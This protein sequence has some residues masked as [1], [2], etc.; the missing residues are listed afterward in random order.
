MSYQSEAKKTDVISVLTLID[1]LRNKSW[2]Y[3][4]STKGKNVK[5]SIMLPSYIIDAKT[6]E[7]INGGNNIIYRANKVVISNAPYTD[8]AREII[9]GKGKLPNDVLKSMQEKNDYFKA[10]IKL[11]TKSSG[12]LGYFT[13]WFN[14]NIWKNA[15]KDLAKRLEL[16]PNESLNIHNMY[17]DSFGSKAN[18]PDPEKK[19]AYMEAKDW[20]YEIKLRGKTA[21]PMNCFGFEVFIYT[22]NY[23]NEII[24]KKIPIN[25]YNICEWFS[26]GTRGTFDFIFSDVTHISNQYSN[27]FYHGR[28]FVTYTLVKE[29]KSEAVDTHTE[30]EKHA[31][32]STINVNDEVDNNDIDEN[33]GNHDCPSTT[34]DIEAQMASIGI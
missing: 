23:K 28:N 4:I 8:T 12:E 5:G 10:L 30:E 22:K 26:K 32:L 27:T 7:P 20:T 14:D 9:N 31:L 15:V 18:T 33:N 24:R 6:K 1:N 2:I 16:D 11:K 19:K 21:E 13:E 34:D 29:P 25:A 17:K 3:Y